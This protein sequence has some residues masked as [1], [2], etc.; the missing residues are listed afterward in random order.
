MQIE[1]KK[2]KCS[3]HSSVFVRIQIQ[4]RAEELLQQ[5]NVNWNKLSE[6]VRKCSTM[7]IIKPK[8]CKVGQSATVHKMITI[9]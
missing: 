1:K 2:F 4:Q 9:S 5:S 8:H 3:F 7:N 6:K